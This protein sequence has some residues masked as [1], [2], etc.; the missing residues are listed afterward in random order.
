VRHLSQILFI[1]LLA[2]GLWGC[3]DNSPPVARAMPPELGRDTYR[4]EADYPKPLP[5]GPRTTVAVSPAAP[6]DETPGADRSVENPPEDQAFLAVY[7]RVNKPKIVLYVNHNTD[8]NL[9]PAID[10]RTG[11]MVNVI[12]REVAD[13]VDAGAIDYNLIESLLS[14]WLSCDGKVTIISAQDARNKLTEDQIKDLQAGKEAALAAVGES[15][16]GHVLIQAQVRAV[17]K[18]DSGAVVRVYAE[19]MNVRGGDLLAQASL[20]VNPPL[21]RAQWNKA[22]QA[23][24]RELMVGL[25]K[26]WSAPMPQHPGDSAAPGEKT[27]TPEEKSEVPVAAEP[28]LTGKKLPAPLPPPP[29]PINE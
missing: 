16:Q 8:G 27:R 19:A 10:P 4:R 18:T 13:D 26:T 5:D 7:N 3:V 1:G 24:A 9:L 22:G 28:K 20:E 11:K 15:T 2:T 6:T 23:L 21:N 17:K 29:A 25:T 12:D 14:D